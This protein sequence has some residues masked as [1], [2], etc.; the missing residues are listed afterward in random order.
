MA[1]TA[2]VIAQLRT[3]EQLTR[4]EIRIARIR[5]AQARTDAVRREL[6]ENGDNAERRAERLAAALR[7]LDAVPDV[8]APVVGRATALVKST[9]EQ[10]QPLDEALLGDLALEHRLL[11][12]ARY[13]L[14]LTDRGGPASVHRLAEQL[15]TA[16]TAT[17]DWLTTVLAEEALGGPAALR[18]TPPQAVT[19]GVTRAVQLPTRLTVGVNRAAQEVSRARDD[20]RR[21]VEEVAG[22]VGR[23]AADTRDVVT[24]GI[25][26]ALERAEGVA[27]R[28]AGRD[29]ARAVHTALRDLGALSADELPV[30]RYDE[31]SVQDAVAAVKKPDSPDDLQ[32]VLRYEE[33]HKNR[34]GVVSAARTRIAALA[35]D[36]VG[37]A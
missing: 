9:V 18:A 12:R 32:A 21:R 17:V 16:H 4:T 37:V 23:L 36:A 20:A 27:R 25:D 10:A 26:A 33:Q 2:A 8:V 6:E 34:S 1:N 13:L 19:A 31:L 3:L 28:D 11:D 15:V 24:T 30:R 5:V 29:A 22:R 14:A 35:K 7:D